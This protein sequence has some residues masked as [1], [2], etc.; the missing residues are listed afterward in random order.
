M[1]YSNEFILPHTL[2]D[3][4]RQVL[5]GGLLGDSSI[6]KDGK[7]PRMKIERQALDKPYIDWEYNIFKDLCK[8]GVKEFERFDKRYN[9]SHKYVS[10]R[11]RAVPA[12]LDYYNKWYPNNIRQVPTDIEFTPLILAV[13]FA[14]DGCI[15]HDGRGV[16]TLKMSTESFGES[17]AEFLSSK[18]KDR[19]GEK[20]PIYRKKKDKDQFFIKASTSAVHPFLKEIQPHI[21]EMG[22][23]RKYNIWKDLDLDTKLKL[24]APEIVRNDLKNLISSF[25]EF[26]LNDLLLKSDIDEN[27]ITYYVNK[28]FKLKYLD[29]FESNEKFKLYHYKLTES[30]RKFFDS[31]KE[32]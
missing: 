12:L 19:F 28:L 2:N 15:I 16:L 32:G 21:I 8:S 13:W 20:Y 29:R 25:N 10:F 5:I 7:F 18:L 1:N 3:I 23:L 22:M 9:K 6:M 27:D 24:G 26:S 14:D 11:T 30:G 31:N 17:G 4:Q